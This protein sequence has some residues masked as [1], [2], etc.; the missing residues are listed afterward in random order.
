MKMR[1]FVVVLMV[2]VVGFAAC[3]PKPP[4]PEKSNNTDIAKFMV[5]S[6]EYTDIKASGEILYTYPKTGT[7]AWASLPTGKN[8]PATITL[9]D[10]KAKTDPSS[11]TLDFTKVGEAGTAGTVGSFD[12]ISESGKK[13]TYT[14]K[15]TKN[16]NQQ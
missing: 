6:I 7:N 3:G 13:K 15:V 10:S 9:E 2:A 16:P 5:G 12:V 4:A 8:E 1:F 14:V 11:V